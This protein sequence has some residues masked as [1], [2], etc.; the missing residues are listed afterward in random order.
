MI[1][2]GLTG[3]SGAGKGALAAAFAAHDVPQLDTDAIYHALLVP[4]SA[5]L[6]ALVDAFGRDILAPDGTLNRRALAAIVF[7]TDA[8][9]ALH[10]T[11]NHITHHYILAETRR[12]IAACRE[13]GK[14]AVLVDA[15]LLYES[16]FDAECEKVIA[17]IA[18]REVRLA[19]I[20]ARDALPREAAEARLRAQKDDEFYTAR[21]DFVVVNDGD[22]GALAGEAARIMAVLGVYAE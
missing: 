22:T 16:G 15:P 11:L 14:P 8:P 3:P 19:R 9:K 10:E 2:L 21:A 17:V 1:V 7:A 13:A 5:C 12:Q 6:D 4:P 20:M 18:P